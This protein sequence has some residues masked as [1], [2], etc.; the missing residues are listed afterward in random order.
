MGPIEKMS[1]SNNNFLL[2]NNSEE[3]SS[4]KRDHLQTKH[5][6][7]Y[8]NLPLAMRPVPH[9]EELPLPKPPQNLTSSRDNSDSEED[10]GQQEGLVFYNDVCSVIEAPG[11]Q[12]NP[13]KWRLLLTLH[14]L[15]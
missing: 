15:A 14:K 7:K 2:C 1:L 4:N 9:S 11:H 3:H 8:S 10:H 6:V 5:T 12:H 13:T